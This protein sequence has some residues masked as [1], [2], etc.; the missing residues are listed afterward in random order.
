MQSAQQREEFDMHWVAE[1]VDKLSAFDCQMNVP[2]IQSEILQGIAQGDLTQAGQS[3]CSLSVN[4]LFPSSCQMD[5]HE[6]S[7]PLPFSYS[8]DVPQTP[9]TC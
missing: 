1:F 3:S 9:V 4:R 8:E 7:L 5:I 6:V 2:V